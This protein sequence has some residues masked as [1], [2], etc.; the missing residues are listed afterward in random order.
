M[1]KILIIGDS[2]VQWIRPYRNHIDNF[3]Y[4]EL[5]EKEGYSVDVISMPG[6]TSKDVMNIY[7]NTLGGKF[8]DIY[9][10]SVGI[11]DLTPRSYPRWMWKINNSLL[12]KKSLLSRIYDFIY[13]L[14]T[15]KFTQKLQNIKF[16]SLG[17]I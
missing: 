6:M 12:I 15:N 5:L 8:Y 4:V 10:V 17:L 16:Q 14:F 7:W 3:T 11:N 2:T 1:K 9:I 13:R